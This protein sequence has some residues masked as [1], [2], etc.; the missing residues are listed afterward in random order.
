MPV[1]KNEKNGTWYAMVRYKDWT[2]QN[3]QKCQRGFATRRE[4]LEWEAQFKLQ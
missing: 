2:G 1:Y 3:K 4:A